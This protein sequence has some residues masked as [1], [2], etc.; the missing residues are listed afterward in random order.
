[1]SLLPLRGLSVNGM[2]VCIKERKRRIAHSF[3]LFQTPQETNFE[4]NEHIYA[5]IVR[6]L[7][8]DLC[9]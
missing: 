4:L 8:H 9:M 5:K 6:P 7:Y 1:M 3:V 2:Y